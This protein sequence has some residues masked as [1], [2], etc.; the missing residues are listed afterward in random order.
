MFCPTGQTSNTASPLSVSL[1]GT[2]V[3]NRV[4][5]Y[6][7]TKTFSMCVKVSSVTPS[8]QRRKRDTFNLTEAWVQ[9]LISRGDVV[10][11][12]GL[13]EDLNDNGPKFVY[14]VV[15]AGGC[16]CTW[17]DRLMD[18]FIDIDR[19][20]DILIWRCC[21]K[22]AILHVHVLPLLV[23]CIFVTWKCE[24]PNQT[25]SYE[26]WLTIDNY[27]CSLLGIKF[28]TA[29]DHVIMHRP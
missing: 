14:P 1:N 29:S 13:V 25:W 22:H 23:N 24:W 16:T 17:L 19:W 8:S 12:E 28:A 18:I 5:D 2:L 6:E 3:T 27:H 11:I 10:L 15:T 7:Q 9:T 20:V 21:G 4:I 26:K